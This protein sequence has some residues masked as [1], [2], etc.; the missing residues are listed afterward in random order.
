MASVAFHQS[1][2]LH[3]QS[4]QGKHSVMKHQIEQCFTHREEGAKLAL[5][6]SVSLLFVSLLPVGFSQQSVQNKWPACTP[7]VPQNEG[8]GSMSSRD[9][10]SRGVGLVP[11]ETHA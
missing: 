7:L 4:H 3:T 5:I 10:Y 8:L 9:R 6:L 1:S 11:Y 2:S